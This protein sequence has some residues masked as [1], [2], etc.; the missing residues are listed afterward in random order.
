MKF[1]TFLE[2]FITGK[3]FKPA[4]DKEEYFELFVNPTP[5][6]LKGIERGIL[7]YSGDFYTI[8]PFEHYRDYIHLDIIRYLQSE[9]VLKNFK[10]KSHFDSHI[11]EF[12]AVSKFNDEWYLSESY[13]YL[14][15]IALD[16]MTNASKKN[17][18]LNFIP[19]RTP[20]AY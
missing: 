4:Y 18:R 5:K 14:P 2:K 12:L 3:N 16:Y 13:Q 10:V 6:E 8:A 17:P 20:D 11:N 15:K 9:K 19:K 1:K 7:L